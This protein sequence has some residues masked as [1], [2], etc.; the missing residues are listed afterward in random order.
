MWWPFFSFGCNCNVYEISSIFKNLRVGRGGTL[1]FSIFSTVTQVK[2]RFWTNATFNPRIWEEDALSRP[3]AAPLVGAG[4]DG[5]RRAWESHNGYRRTYCPYLG[6][7]R[8]ARAIFAAI[9]TFTTLSSGP[10]GYL[11]RGRCS[12]YRPVGANYQFRD[13]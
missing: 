2:A 4:V 1:G 5:C 9:D 6:G 10:R 8:K 3:S 12:D 11:S 7:N 13:D